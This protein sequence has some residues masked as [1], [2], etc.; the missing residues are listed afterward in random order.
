MSDDTSTNWSAST[1]EGARG[2]KLRRWRQ[3]SLHQK[4][5]AVDQLNELG[6]TLIAA[7]KAKGLPYIDPK[8]GE[9]IPKQ[10]VAEDAAQYNRQ[11]D[12]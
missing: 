8:T 2:E 3:L 11:E 6:A 1:W 12:S 10:S 4:L 5:D 7:R 9:R